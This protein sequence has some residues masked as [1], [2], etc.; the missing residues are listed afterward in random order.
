MLLL[1][2]EL[3][4]HLF[5]NREEP[6]QMKYAAEYFFTDDNGITKAIPDGRYSTT[7]FVKATGRKIYDVTYS[8][9]SESRRVTPTT[10]NGQREKFIL[11]FGGSFTFGEGLEDNETIPYYTGQYAKGFM[12]YNYG[13]HGH[14]AAEMLIK[15]RSM[16]IQE[17][18]EQDR[19]VLIYTFIDAHIIRVVGSMRVVTTW[20][21][22]RPFF[23][24]D[25]IGTLHKDGSFESGRPGLML[26][27]RL[28]SKSKILELLN[29]D[30]P[31]KITDNHFELFTVIVE[32][33]YKS[34][35]K[36]FPESDFYFLIYPR[37]QYTAVLKR[38]L[39]RKKIPYLDYSM[40]ID[41]WNPKF[42]LAPEDRHPNALANRI[43]ARKIVED[44]GLNSD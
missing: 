5:H 26:L 44:L 12:P 25:K 24:L 6:V 36:Q 27:Y 38:F 13:F 17:E 32:E 11:F 8:I 16:T 20:G 28:L 2:V 15:L 1:T 35:K 34:Y 40:F 39:D 29:V 14:S 3:F 7:S 19:G 41:R 21:K 43:V 33:A 22:N 30:L 42:I 9:D 10:S 37:S 18:I 4:L 31:Y 23:Y